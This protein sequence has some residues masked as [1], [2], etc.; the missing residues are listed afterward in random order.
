M[1]IGKNTFIRVR[2]EHG[3]ESANPAEF[4]F[5]LLELGRK[6]TNLDGEPLVMKPLGVE[7]AIEIQVTGPV[8]RSVRKSEVN[9]VVGPDVMIQ[10]TRARE[11]RGGG[12][13]YRGD[14]LKT[15]RE[16]DAYVKRV[17]GHS[18]RSQFSEFMY[19]VNATGEI[20]GII[21]D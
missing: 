21:I 7:P 19:E 14:M 13:G 1:K 9:M 5:N 18:A 12:K 2:N 15:A 17:R 8:P 6:L 4:T 20:H 11:I 10:G 16:G 3:K